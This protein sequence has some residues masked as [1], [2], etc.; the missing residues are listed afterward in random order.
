MSLSLTK[1]T[2]KEIFAMFALEESLENSVAY[3]EIIGIGR[4]EEEEIGEIKG[5]EIGEEIGEI[6]G[7]EI[8]K[9]IGVVAGRLENLKELYAE[10]AITKEIFQEH[11]K[12]YQLQLTELLAKY[13]EPLLS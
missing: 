13:D 12:K 3:Q 7:K 1:K 2:R 11:E 10:D 4:L 9:E 5:K 6:R 8:G